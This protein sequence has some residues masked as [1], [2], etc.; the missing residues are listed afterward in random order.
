MEI[1]T[2]SLV[3]LLVLIPGFLSSTILDMVMVRASRESWAKLI[4]ALMLSFLIYVV[5]GGV[6][7]LS[8]FA[9]SDPK[10]PQ[11]IEKLRALISPVFL[12]ATLVTATL[13]PLLMGFVARRNWHMRLLHRFGVTERT[14]RS[15]VWLDVF[16]EQKGYVICNL[17]GGRRIFGW[18]LYNAESL[19]GPLVYLHDPSWIETNGNYVSLGVAGILLME[20]DGIESIEFMKAPRATSSELEDQVER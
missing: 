13:L 4:E 10:V 14:G 3:I 2:E 1:S 6:L 18:P 5:V 11:D 8:P 9:T 19:E 20:K 15:T 12:L 16:A 7:R 17:T